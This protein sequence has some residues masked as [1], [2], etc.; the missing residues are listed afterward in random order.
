MGSKDRRV[1][2]YISKAAPFAKPI[3]KHLRDVVHSACPEAEETIKWGSPTFMYEGMLCGM[4]AFQQHCTFGFWKGELVLD[5]KGNRADEAMGQFGRLAQI[6]DLP[7][8]KVLTGYIR[9]AMKL[10]ETGAKLPSRSKPRMKRP[11]IVP[12]VLTSA[13]KKNRKAKTT[14]DELNPSQQR[15]Y[16]EWITEAKRDET[17]TK[18]LETTI[19]WLAEGKSRNWKYENC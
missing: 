7:S 13:L 8:K 18:R 11:V 17:R 15:D 12:P 3:L 10:N 2:A 5:A 14:F 9:T 1:D 6:S 16:I 4:A 19:E